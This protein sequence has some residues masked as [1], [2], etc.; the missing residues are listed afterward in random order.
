MSTIEADFFRSKRSW[1]KIKDKVL[2]EYMPAYLGKVARLGREILLVDGRAG[3]GIFDDG[4][5]GSPIIMCEAAG[6]M[7]ATSMWHCS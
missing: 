2:S 1:S 6:G 4:S 7:H 3:P 5:Y